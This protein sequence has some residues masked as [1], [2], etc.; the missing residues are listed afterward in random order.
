MEYC[1]AYLIN[2]N[3]VSRQ[4]WWACN[5]MKIYRKMGLSI[6]RFDFKFV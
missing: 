1:Q 3:G 6:G 2:E 4:M 5:T